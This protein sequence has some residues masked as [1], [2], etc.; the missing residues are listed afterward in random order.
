MARYL[1]L[2]FSHQGFTEEIEDYF[3]ICLD[4]M[5]KTFEPIL[6]FLIQAKAFRLG[7][8]LCLGCR[9]QIACEI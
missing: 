3:V 8:D 2:G 5:A 4:K 9:G 7:L 1:I 6:K